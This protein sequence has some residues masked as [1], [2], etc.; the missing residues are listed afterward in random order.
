[1][2]LL[3]SNCLFCSSQK[4]RDKA[5]LVPLSLKNKN[6]GPN[7][8]TIV[9]VSPDQIED[10]KTKQKTTHKDVFFVCFVFSI[11]GDPSRKTSETRRKKGS[12]CLQ[13]FFLPVLAFASDLKIS[14]TITASNPTSCVCPHTNRDLL[15]SIR[16]RFL[17]GNFLCVQSKTTTHNK[18]TT[19]HGRGS[20]CLNVCA[21]T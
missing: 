4:A 21:S 20:D 5:P 14:R 18:T 17:V 9:R 2:G 10:H 15:E 7:R 19:T 6:D 1:M 13:T 8:N 11:F 16:Q 12:F 3:S